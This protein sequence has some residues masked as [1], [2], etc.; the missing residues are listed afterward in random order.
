M[1]EPR[2]PRSLR[3][4]LAALLVAGA[5]GG[6]YVTGQ[7]SAQRALVVPDEIN[8][9]EVVRGARSAVV[10]VNNALAPEALMPGD[11]PVE[12]GTGFFY[13]KDLIVTAY[14][15]VQDSENLT[16]TLQ[17]GRTVPAKV[18]GVDPGIDVAV[19]RVTA[20][21]AP[22]TLEFGS[23]AALVQGQKLITIGSPFKIQNFVGTGVFSVMAPATQIPRSDNLASEVGEYIISTNSIQ[24]GNSGG[25]ILDSR[26][27]VVGIANANAAANS[28]AA[29]LIGISIPG[30]LVKQTLSDLER[31]GAPQRGNLGVTLVG[32]ED[33]DPALRQLAGLVSNQGVLVDEIQAGSPAGRAGLRGS[34][35]NSRGQLLAPLGDIIVAVDGRPVSQPF[36]VTS[37]VAARR[38]G[39]VV[40]LT[41]WR[42][43]RRQELSVTLQQR[44]LEEFQSQSQGSAG[45]VPQDLGPQ[46][47][48]TQGLGTPESGAPS[49]GAPDAQEPASDQLAPVSP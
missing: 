12:V 13:K 22:A 3:P 19:L 1:T 5:A 31:T 20:V 14:H 41:V 30:D 33:L 29:G 42:D 16:V 49:Q 7:V 4:W 15:V 40:R 24:G 34:L 35:R 46:G 8:T 36:D 10:Q 44:S 38:P 18:E 9:T 23:S 28:M 26:G 32:L 21:T 45:P 6:A 27:A 37:L 47:P 25:P 39:D 11:D 17:N 48:G 2:S 43:G